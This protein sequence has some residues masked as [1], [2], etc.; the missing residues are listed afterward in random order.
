[1]LAVTDSSTSSIP[2]D[3]SYSA[4]FVSQVLEGDD[5]VYALPDMRV[6]KITKGRLFR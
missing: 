6:S 1:M 5:V 3:I 2:T 4:D